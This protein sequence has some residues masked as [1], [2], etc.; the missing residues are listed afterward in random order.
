MQ[1]G[2]DRNSDA[3]YWDMLTLNDLLFKEVNSALPCYSVSPRTE[4]NVSMTQISLTLDNI[5][6]LSL[7]LPGKCM[8]IP[9]W[10]Y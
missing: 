5:V 1:L 9:I 4:K 6:I 8:G 3:A 10:F 7:V 2:N